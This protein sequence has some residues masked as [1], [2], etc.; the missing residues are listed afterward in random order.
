[1]GNGT[2]LLMI[3]TFF[4]LLCFPLILAESVTIQK[5]KA[6]LNKHLENDHNGEINRAKSRGNGGA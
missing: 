6:K 1:M 5:I 3:A 2:E 4:L